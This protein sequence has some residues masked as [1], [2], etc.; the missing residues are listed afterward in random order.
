[1]ARASRLG[2]V[3][4]AGRAPALHSRADSLCPALSRMNAGSDGRHVPPVGWLMRDVPGQ[5]RA[6]SP[7]EPSLLVAL[8]HPEL[9]EEDAPLQLVLVVPDS[10]RDDVDLLERV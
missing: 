6:K 5:I 4:S 2:A 9:I 3:S 1:M 10:A 8:A 7:R